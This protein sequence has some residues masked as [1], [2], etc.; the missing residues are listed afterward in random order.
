MAVKNKVD[1][2]VIVAAT[3]G[4]M[5]AIGMILENYSGLIEK[6]V[7]CLAS[8]LPEECRRDC[9]QEV[10]IDLVKKIQTKFKI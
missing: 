10:M 6:A 1:Y 7:Y 5:V 8:E 3:K 4:N 9:K 2:D